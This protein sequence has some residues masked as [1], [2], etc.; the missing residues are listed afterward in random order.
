[1]NI[2]INDTQIPGC[3]EIVLP[4]IADVRG[5]FVKIF[6]GD[7]FLN[8]GLVTHF[9]EEYYSVSHHGVIRGM[10]FQIPPYDHVKLVYCIT[11]IILDAV[12]DLRVGSPSFKKYATFNL[13]ADNPSLIYIP[14]GLAHGFYVLSESAVVLYKVST[15]YDQGH[16]FGILWNSLGIPW[17]NMNP[18]ISDR[19]RQ[20]PNI[21]EFQ[22]P[23]IF[24]L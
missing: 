20:F 22:S 14:P 9:P 12:V 18:I 1:M 13:R 2:K 10:H 8:L 16:D 3:Y 5:S 15:T 11:G 19:D 24:Q 17:P 4:T 6:H 7:V 21:E 23:F